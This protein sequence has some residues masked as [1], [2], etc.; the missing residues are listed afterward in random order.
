MIFRQQ[1]LQREVRERRRQ[2]M[3]QRNMLHRHVIEFGQLLHRDLGTA[4]LLG[5]GFGAGF[6]LAKV[7]PHWRSLYSTVKFGMALLRT[8]LV[9]RG[10]TR[11]ITSMR[12]PD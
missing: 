10:L 4:G 7:R 6:L 9:G 1:R 3:D 5:W 11:L 12:P 2:L 8:A